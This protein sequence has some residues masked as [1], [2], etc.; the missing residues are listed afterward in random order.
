MKIGSLENQKSPK[1]AKMEI[2][3]RQWDT[4]AVVGLASNLVYIYIYIICTS[5]FISVEEEGPPMSTV[6]VKNITILTELPFV[7]SFQERVKV[8]KFG[9]ILDFYDSI[10]KHTLYRSQS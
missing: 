8:G 4:Y 5:N 10:H 6:E 9:I 1:N 3:G 7:V 2:F